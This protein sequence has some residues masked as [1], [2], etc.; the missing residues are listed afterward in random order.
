MNPNQYSVQTSRAGAIDAGLRAHMQRIYNRMTFGVLVTALVSY[1]VAQ[2]PA[3]LQAVTQGPIMWL[4]VLAPLGIVMFGF[5]PARMSSQALSVSFTALSVLYGLSFAVI[6]HVFTGES[7]ARAFFIAAGMFAGL[8]IFGY[9]TR[10]NLDGLGTFA[11]MGVWGILIASVI[12]LVMPLF[13]VAMPTGFSMIISAV[14]VVAFSALTAWETQRMKEMYSPSM[15]DEGNSRLAW[16]GA[17]NL[18]I[19]FVVLF[20]SILNL[21]GNRN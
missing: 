20:Q 9:T 7:I 4:V 19:S 8:S 1:F 17:L 6:F 16:A 14:S 2:S 11:V 10:K 15:G 12:G 21:I 5:N 3:L 18:Y 13:G